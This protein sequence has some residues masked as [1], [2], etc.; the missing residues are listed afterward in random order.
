MQSNKNIF[1]SIILETQLSQINVILIISRDLK[2]TKTTVCA[3]VKWGGMETSSLM[4]KV[5]TTEQIN[6]RRNNFPSLTL[7]MCVL[8]EK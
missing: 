8:H 3:L 7:L 4:I 2:K 5:K 1:T 6:K